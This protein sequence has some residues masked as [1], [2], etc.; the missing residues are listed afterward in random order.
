MSK[1]YALLFFTLFQQQFP[2]SH[3]RSSRCQDGK[4]ASK[5]RMFVF[6]NEMLGIA[7]FSQ[8]EETYERHDVC[9]FP[10]I[11]REFLLFQSSYQNCSIMRQLAKNL[12]RTG[13]K[14]HFESIPASQFSLP[15]EDAKQK[16]PSSPKAFLKF[17]MS[18]QLADPEDPHNQWFA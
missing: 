16:E 11:H 14:K 6:V 1:I 3:S 8:D 5:N 2:A 9:S 12:S 7:F 18:G 17:S 4:E 15:T 13:S 10:K